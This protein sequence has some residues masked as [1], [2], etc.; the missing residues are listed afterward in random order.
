MLRL[1]H[2]RDEVHHWL[3]EMT[4]EDHCGV[5]Q[6][7]GRWRRRR[8]QRRE[9]TQPRQDRLFGDA[10]LRPILP[11]G[12]FGDRLFEFVADGDGTGHPLASWHGAQ[13]PRL[14]KERVPEW[15][16]GE[17]GDAMDAPDV[18]HFWAK[19]GRPHLPRR[20]QWLIL[21]RPAT[22]VALTRG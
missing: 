10:R 7:R 18:G 9:V 21:R 17:G 16:V 8:W 2:L 3:W 12:Q 14:V 11:R 15:T 22:E 6:S 4:Q 1:A 19:H 13:A 20:Q 5:R